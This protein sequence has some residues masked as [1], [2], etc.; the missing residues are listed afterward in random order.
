MLRYNRKKFKE[1]LKGE[2]MKRKLIFLVLCFCIIMTGCTDNEESTTEEIII[3]DLTSVA[4]GV[5]SYEEFQ[6]LNAGAPVVVDLTV[7]DKGNWEDYKASLT[8]E[9]SQAV[10]DLEQVTC[11][12]EEFDHLSPGMKVRVT[13]YKAEETEAKIIDASFEIIER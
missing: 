4:E 2:A 5:M 1:K 7:K 9:D 12:E 8:G 13:G 3:E 11:S 10:Y 6:S